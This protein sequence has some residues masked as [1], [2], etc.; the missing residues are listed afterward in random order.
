MEHDLLFCELLLGALLWLGMH[1]Y[2]WWQR[3]STAKHPPATQTKRSPQAPKPFTAL[4][5]KPPCELCEQSQEHS[6]PPPLSPP[7]VIASK[8]GRPRTIATHQHHCPE[9][10]CPYY[11]WVG[12][13]NIHA[14]GHPGGGPWRQLQCIMCQTYFLET[15][16]TVFHGK[17]VPAELLVQ[18][19]AA[20]AEGV[21]LRAVARVF[22]VDPN[23]VLTWLSEAADHLKAFSHYLLHD[24]HVNH[25]QLD[26][27]CA[28]VSEVKPGQGSEAAAT[29]HCPRSPYWVWV[30]V[31]PVS[32]LLLALDVGERTL[33]MA[34]RLVHHVRQVLASGC[35]PL[36]V[37]DGLKE[38]ATAL[39]THFG[40]WV[41]P[42]R[43]QATGPAP[44]P[45][46]M[47]RPEL[48][49]AQVVKVY[50]RRHLVC[51]HPRV[52]FG[53]LAQVMHLLAPRGWRINTAFI[54]RI[55]LTLRHHVAA[56]GR[57]VMTV[58]K[59]P[60][61]LH[62]QLHLYHIYYNFCLPHVSLRVPLAHPLLTNGT[63]S[64]KRW[65]PCTPAMAAGLTDQVWS[66]ARLYPFGEGFERRATGL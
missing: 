39:L 43:P 42:P 27:L 57:R 53:T 35:L 22:E 25:V 5:H 59:S 46:W 62:D 29:E 9:K 2:W 51:M 31:D 66:L 30:A 3:G 7:P 45:R 41:Q 63:G 64:A 37:T 24:V 10:T 21:G 54:E 26:E 4:T 6:D 61:G 40:H 28:W 20:L 60:G 65:R 55:N 19:V 23:T 58:A 14:N 50:R 36:F 17:R 11:G 18:V 34:Q 47:P 16:G 49:Y 1:V 13:G 48:L 38:Y 32:K 8:R 52:V 33:K 12:R 15:H 56:V 44:K